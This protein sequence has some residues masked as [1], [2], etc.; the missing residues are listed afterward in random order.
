[1]AR[2]RKSWAEK[3]A[4][5]AE[6]QV[7]RIS[8]DM[9]GM[10]SGQMIVIATPRIVEDYIRAIPPGQSVGLAQ[11][12]SDLAA[13]YDADATCPLTAGIFLRIVAEAANEAHEAGAALS[14]IA[15]VWR[16]IDERSPTL[17][18]LSFDPG[19]MLQMRDLE[20][21]SAAAAR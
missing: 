19:Y 8:K 11:M 18:K 15:P 14:D 10:K 21:C 3:M 1:M 5:P 9:A 4:E 7:K 16:M 17:R 20:G 6:P 13:R 12:R 2:R